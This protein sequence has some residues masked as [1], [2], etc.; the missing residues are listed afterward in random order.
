MFLIPDF[1]FSNFIEFDTFF[2]QLCYPACEILAPGPGIKPAP[3]VVDSGYLNHWT[4]REVPDA[5][6]VILAKKFKVKSQPLMSSFCY[7]IEGLG[8]AGE[9]GKQAVNL[10]HSQS[11]AKAKS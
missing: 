1:Y 9:R 4:A 8:A 5:P 6:F 2:F 3:S 7:R 10:I 11:Y